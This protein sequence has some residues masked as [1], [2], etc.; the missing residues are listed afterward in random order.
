MMDNIRL[1]RKRTTEDGISYLI[2]VSDMEYLIFGTST[3]GAIKL[4]VAQCERPELLKGELIPVDLG[5]YMD[6]LREAYRTFSR[7]HDKYG[8]GMPAFND[9]EMNIAREVSELCARITSHPNM[10]MGHA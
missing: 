7:V 9:S 3:S 2:P 6:E 8:A 5:P 1:I 10:Q 4:G